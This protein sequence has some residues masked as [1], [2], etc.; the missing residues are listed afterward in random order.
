MARLRLNQELRNKISVV[1]E[2]ILNKKKLKRKKNFFK[3]VRKYETFATDNTWD[4]TCTLLLEDI[5]HHDD[6]KMARSFTNKF[7]NVDTIASDSCFHF[8]YMGKV[9]G[10]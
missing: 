1:C 9:E 5:I 7:D 8:G 4:L 3:S 10:T 2:F 6:V